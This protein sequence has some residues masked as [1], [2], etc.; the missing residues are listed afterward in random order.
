MD[1]ERLKEMEALTLERLWAEF[2]VED[3]LKAKVGCSWSHQNKY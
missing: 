3:N 2:V 1:G